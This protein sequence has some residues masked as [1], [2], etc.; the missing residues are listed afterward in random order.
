MALDGKTAIVTGGASG[1]GYACVRRI[2]DDGARVVLAD[3]DEDKGEAA[4]EELSDYGEVRFVQCDVGERLDVHNLVA[5]TLDAYDDI[6]ILVSNAGIVHKAHFLELTEDDFDRVMRTNIKGA[7]LCG[8]AVAQHLVDRVNGG[9]APGA[10][11][12]MS[13]V[14]AI[15]GLPDQVPY[16]V[17]KGGVSQ[18]TKVMAIALA[19][20]GIRVNAVGPGSVMTEMLASVVGDEAAKEK[21]LARTPIGRIGE[22]SEIA[23]IVA[24]LASDEASY[25]TGQTIYA[26][27]GRLGLNYTMPPPSPTAGGR[28]QDQGRG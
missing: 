18:L 6:D 19:P 2:L 16:S 7:F 12:N 27:G 11:V 17:S 9:D 15:F 8:Q 28:G 14:N 3:I 5:R 26:D 13:S 10:I 24:W 4:V 22:P 25:V 20:H 21:I 23:A 1:I